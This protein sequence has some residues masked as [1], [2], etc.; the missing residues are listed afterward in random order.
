M[1]YSCISP[2]QLKNTELFSAIPEM[3][4]NRFISPYTLMPKYFVYGT[5]SKNTFVWKMPVV[6]CVMGIKEEL[7]LV[8]CCNMSAWE[9][10]TNACWAGTFNSSFH[11][12]KS[13][14]GRESHNS[15]S[16]EVV[17]MGEGWR[18]WPD[19]PVEEDK[20]RILVFCDLSRPSLPFFLNPFHYLL[21][22]QL[23]KN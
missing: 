1:S 10:F 11:R 12:E 8:I 13:W 16:A 15:S 4:K 3:N 9:E 20:E 18:L 23:L 5:P 22:L 7:V 6:L 2:D 14:Q 21:P 17:P 19:C